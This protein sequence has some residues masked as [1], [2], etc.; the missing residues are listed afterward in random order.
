MLAEVGDFAGDCVD[1]VVLVGVV[2][3]VFAVEVGVVEVTVMEVVGA[4]EV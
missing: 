3:M 2:V 1:A 4:V